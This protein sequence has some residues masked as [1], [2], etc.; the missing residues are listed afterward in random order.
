MEIRRVSGPKGSPDGRQ[1]DYTGPHRRRAPVHQDEAERRRRA[2][3]DDQE[4]EPPCALPDLP[5]DLH[6]R[7]DHGAEH[8]PGHERAESRR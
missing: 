3:P 6:H 4:R 2:A 1:R 7:A 8:L 5:A